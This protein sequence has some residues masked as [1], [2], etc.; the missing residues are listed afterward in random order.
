MCCIFYLKGAGELEQEAEN[1]SSSSVHPTE[2]QFWIQSDASD[3]R[4]TP[5]VG[6]WSS[7]TTESHPQ[8][9]LTLGPVTFW[10]PVDWSV[11]TSVWPSENTWCSAADGCWP[12]HSHQSSFSL[13]VTNRHWLTHCSRSSAATENWILWKASA[14]VKSCSDVTHGYRASVLLILFIQM[15]LSVKDSSHVTSDSIISWDGSCLI[16][17]C[18]SNLKSESLTC[19]Y[20]QTLSSNLWGNSFGSIRA[21]RWLYINQQHRN[22]SDD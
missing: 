1:C 8:L 4:F 7:M 22:L 11:E 5:G 21:E 9:S 20:T 2:N 17:N 12:S 19:C 6:R 3:S 10:F 13:T 15:L 14:S 18:W 16:E